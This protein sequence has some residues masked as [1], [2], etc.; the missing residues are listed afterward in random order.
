MWHCPATTVWQ[1]GSARSC[2]CM[3]DDV[4]ETGAFLV[5]T[6]VTYAKLVSEG[7]AA[8]LPSDMVS[9]VGSLLADGLS[10]VRLAHDAG[11]QP[12]AQLGFLFRRSRS[13]S[14]HCVHLISAMWLAVHGN[15]RA[16]LL[17]DLGRRW[18]E[19]GCD[20]KATSTSQSCKPSNG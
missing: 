14:V 8:G 2:S 16:G 18:T 10:A 13:C 11:A 20:F 1:P 6:L 4:Q 3:L 15:A 12:I 7:P 19:T 5:P 9:K 17:G